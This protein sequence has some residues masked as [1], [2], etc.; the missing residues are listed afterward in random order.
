[1]ELFARLHAIFGTLSRWA[2]WAGGFALMLSA[3]MVTLDVFSRKLFNVTMSGSD[4]ISGY[5]FA[6]ATTWAYAYCLLH[7]SNI[8]IDALYNL[9]PR[10][11]RAVMDIVGLL[12]LLVFMGYLTKQAVGVFAETWENDSLAATTLN[13]PLVYPQFVWLSGLLFFNLTLVFMIVY[14]TLALFVQGPGAV[15]KL[16]GTMSVQEEIESETRGVHEM[17]K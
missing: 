15:Q 17:E 8:R 7:R 10:A 11:V 2:V 9:F 1:M 3:I 14:T 13:T 16:A 5:V 12:L 4:E 6:G